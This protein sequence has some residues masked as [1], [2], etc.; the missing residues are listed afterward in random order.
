MD[1]NRQ[2]KG[3]FIALLP[4][5]IFIVAYLGVGLYLTSKNVEMAFYQFKA[6][7]AVILGIVAAFLLTK[8]SIDEKFDTF[9]KGC[10]DDNIIIMCIML[11][12]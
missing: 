5:I 12:Q 3:S 10:G 9:I 8:G 4:F 1:K 2:E 11:F 7:V 6:P